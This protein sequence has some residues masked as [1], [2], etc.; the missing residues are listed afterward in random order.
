[1]VIILWLFNLAFYKE[2]DYVYVGGSHHNNVLW[3]CFFSCYYL[4]LQV[5]ILARNNHCSLI[6]VR[7]ELSMYCICHSF[8]HVYLKDDE[9]IEKSDKHYCCNCYDKF[10]FKC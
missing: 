9:F 6:F 5:L 1:M 7:R 2:T 4:E 10:D 8:C 3:S